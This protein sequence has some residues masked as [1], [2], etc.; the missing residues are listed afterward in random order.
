MHEKVTKMLEVMIRSMLGKSGGAILDWLRS[1]PMATTTI[2]ALFLFV[3]MLGRWQLHRIERR[4]AQLVLEMSREW[5]AKKPNITA[6]GL[7]KRIYPRWS[8][9]VQN[10]GVF[11]PHRLELWPV[12]VR[13][14][15]VQSKI[16][17]SPQWI[18]S[19][20]AKHGIQLKAPGDEIQDEQ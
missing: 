3:Y 15:T 17:F 2:F 6:T 1:H 10:W 7:Y 5:L 9:S 20:L 4:T 11:I 13:P 12:P 18:A 8:Q 19:L 16:S 14:E